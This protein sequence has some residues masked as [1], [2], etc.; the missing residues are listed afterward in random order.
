MKNVLVMM[1][2]FAVMAVILVQSGKIIDS[3]NLRGSWQ[4]KA[5]IV[6][7]ILII[8]GV[9]VALSDGNPMG[10]VEREYYRR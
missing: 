10:Y 9:L 1:V 5:V 3:L 6:V 4:E 2:V 7:A 8:I